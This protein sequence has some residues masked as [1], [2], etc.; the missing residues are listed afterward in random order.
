MPQLE[1]WLLDIT[2]KAKYQ[3]RSRGMLTYGTS[4]CLGM[5]DYQKCLHAVVIPQNIGKGI[6]KYA[7]SISIYHKGETHIQENIKRS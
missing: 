6:Q 3:L 2:I 1:H 4:V 7:G 5:I